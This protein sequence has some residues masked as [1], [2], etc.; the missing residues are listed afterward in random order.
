MSADPRRISIAEPV[1][2][3]KRI[4]IRENG[5]PLVDFTTLC[6][7]LRLITSRFVYRRETVI[8]R[9]VAEML[10]RANDH[11]LTKGFRL[12]IVEGWRPPFIQKR[13]YAAALKRWQSRHPEWTEVKL[14]RVANQFTAPPSRRVPPP[15]TTGG[16][17]DLFLA[18]RNGKPLDHVAPYKDGDPKGFYF[19]APGLDGESQRARELLAEALIPTGLT[20]YPSEFWHWSFGD[21]GWAYRGGHAAALFGSIEPEGWL[22]DPAD[23]KDEPLEWREEPNDP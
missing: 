6:P 12:A 8:R 15:H 23:V 20:N 19:A 9:S 18:D 7:E 13:M 17:V 4:P 10:C 1:T 5:E 2:E 16:A 11:L 14:R 22:P 3:L 21:Q